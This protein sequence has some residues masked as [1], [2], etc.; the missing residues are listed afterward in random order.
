MVLFDKYEKPVLRGMTEEAAS[1]ACDKFE[2]WVYNTAHDVS[3]EEW[4][5]RVSMI[6]ELNDEYFKLFG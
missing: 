1:A 3:E 2:D 5:H 6:H 4:D